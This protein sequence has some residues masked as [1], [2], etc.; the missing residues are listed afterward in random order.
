MGYELMERRDNFI[1]IRN[2]NGDV[3]EYDILQVFPFTSSKKRMGIIV[4]HR[5][6]DKIIFYLK[7]AEDVIKDKV[8]NKFSSEI[9]EKCGDLA[10]EG[11]RTLVITQKL[12]LPEEYDTWERKY[13]EAEVAL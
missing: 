7:G 6:S 3:E 1:K 5:G 9:I 11:L 8:N 13:N 4:K 10:R 12:L 2:A